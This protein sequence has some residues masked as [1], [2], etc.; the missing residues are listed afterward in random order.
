M[1]LRNGLDV[2]LALDS[3]GYHEV[4]AAV[5]QRIA[6]SSF[7]PAWQPF[8]AHLI[9]SGAQPGGVLQKLAR[10]QHRTGDGAPCECAGIKRMPDGRYRATHGDEI[11]PYM[12]PDRM[13]TEVR[14]MITAEFRRLNTQGKMIVA[15]ALIKAGHDLVDLGIAEAVTDDAVSVA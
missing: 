3:T 2:P 6:Q 11:G 7:D 13:T 15:E 9:M 10:A 14:R 8:M 1:T 5:A 4:P 12:I